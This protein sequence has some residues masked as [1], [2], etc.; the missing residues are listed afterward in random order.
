[1]AD[2]LS[3][4]LFVIAVDG[5][6]AS[7]KGTLARKIAAALNCA[8]MDT[9]ALYRGVG[10]EVLAAGD[11]PDDEAAALRAAE[12]LREK[13]RVAGHDPSLPDPLA[14]PRLREDSVAGAASKVAAIGSVRAALIA[15][16]RDFA[17]RPGEGFAGAVLDGRD[18][19]T[20][21]CPAADVK[22]FITASVEVRTQRRLK[23]LQSRG[24]A[25]TKDAVLRDMRERDARDAERKTAPMKPAEDAV[26]IDTSALG[27]DGVLEQALAAIRKKLPRP[28]A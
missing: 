24:V 4:K 26:R 9:G 27:P 5:P 14:N 7:G 8:H 21:I 6:A 23:E 28:R 15:L 10:F 22:L 12:T 25:V 11:A 3:D 18:I 2:V 17:S 20:V 1:M 13:I 16:Q 19:G